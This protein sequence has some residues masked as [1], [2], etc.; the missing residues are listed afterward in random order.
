MGHMLL[1]RYIKMTWLGNRL[2]TRHIKMTHRFSQRLVVGWCIKYISRLRVELFFPTRQAQM[3]YRLAHVCG[4]CM[5]LHGHPYVK[6]KHNFSIKFKSAVVTSEGLFTGVGFHVFLEVTLLTELLVAEIAH[7]RFL[8]CV[9]TDVLLKNG[10]L[11]E[12]FPAEVAGVWLLPS[13]D[14]D[15]LCEDCLLT[16]LLVTEVTRKRFLPSVDTDVLHQDRFLTELL[17][18]AV[19]VIRL[20]TCVDT[21]MLM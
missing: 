7:K 16:E 3:T 11:S 4:I 20:L 14:T 1:R 13:V 5:V 17:S 2:I 19:T 9:D 8:A 10:L 15:V 18:A 6:I 12:L 21:N